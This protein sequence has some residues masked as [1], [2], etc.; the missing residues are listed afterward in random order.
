MRHA[1]D[2]DQGLQFGVEK[3][4][5]A[6]TDSAHRCVRPRARQSWNLS[7]VPWVLPHSAVCAAQDPVDET[8]G[9]DIVQDA[10]VE[11]A[12]I[13]VPTASGVV[14]SA[15][16]SDGHATDVVKAMLQGQARTMETTVS[17]RLS[18]KGWRPRC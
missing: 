13:V 14:P 6:G 5:K 16:L 17:T 4:C 1:R 10:D 18:M 9:V 2:S 7:Q 11:A 8:V 3:T 15:P 12:T